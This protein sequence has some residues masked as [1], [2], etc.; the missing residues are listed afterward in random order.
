MLANSPRVDDA[1]TIV[2]ELAGNAL[3]HTSSG[4]GGTFTVRVTTKPGWALIEVADEGTGPW[5]RNLAPSDEEEECGR[6]LAIVT[7]LADGLG[8]DIEPTGQTTWA[9][10][11]WPIDDST[12]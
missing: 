6:G 4:T 3:R 9:E 1:E 12:P 11:A 8:H 2:S 10:L 7:A 5:V